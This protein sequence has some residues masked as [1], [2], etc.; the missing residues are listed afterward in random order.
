MKTSTLGRYLAREIWLSVGFVLLALVALFFVL[1]LMQE[2]QEIGRAQYKLQHAALFV[3]LELPAIAYQVMPIAALIGAIYALAQFAANSEYTI[4]RV[5]GMSTWRAARTIAGAALALVVITFFV[6]EYLAP[7]AA[8]YAK[9]MKLAQLG[10]AASAE[11]RSGFW[12][13]DVVLDDAGNETGVRF[14][15]ASEVLPDGT[16]RG[17]KL[18][19]FDLQRRLRSLGQAVSAVYEPGAGWQL[20]DLTETRFIPSKAEQGMFAGQEMVYETK[21]FHAQGGLWPA[22]VDADVF[23]SVFVDPGDM[24][25]MGLWNYIDHL[26]ATRQKTIK[27]EIALWKKAMYPLAVVFMMLLA[28]PFA[29]LHTRSGGVSLKIFAGIMLGIGFYVINEL[30]SHVGA[31]R[32]WPPAL[33]ALAPSLLALAIAAVWLRWV[34][35]H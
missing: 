2:L 4:M 11:F 13:K 18:F 15:N 33:V 8:A 12:V 25:V 5:S 32:E 3:A 35:R 20:R 1:D 31:L 19:E 23:A 6:G 9:K 10:R 21:V 24:S 17:V 28:L 29:Y 14:V 7:P 27:Y 22:R 16:L 34:E 30:S 26:K